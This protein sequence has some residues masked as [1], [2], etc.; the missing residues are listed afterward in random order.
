MLYCVVLRAAASCDDDVKEKEKTLRQG[1]RGREGSSTRLSF[2]EVR[3]CCF[4]DSKSQ[5]EEG[6]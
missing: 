4:V 3:Y 5:E 6:S 1:E 2:N